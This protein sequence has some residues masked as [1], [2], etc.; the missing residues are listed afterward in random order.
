MH[1][2]FDAL[3]SDFQR[4]QDTLKVIIEGGGSRTGLMAIKE[5]TADIGLSSFKFD[6]NKTL[7]DDHQVNQRVVAYDGIV[8]I[9]NTNNPLKQLTN[10]QISQIYSG[11]VKD[12]SEIGGSQG[13]IKPIVR[14]SNS[15]TQRFFTNYF[16]VNEV[17]SSAI[18]AKENHEIVDEVISSENGIGFIGYAYYTEMVNTVELPHADDADS[19][20]V[21]YIPPTPTHLSNGKYPLK[22]SLQIYYHREQDPRVGAFLAYLNTDRAKHIIESFG[23]IAM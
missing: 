4:M 18:V 1:E 7:G 2:T 22:R 11:E 9:N 15:G 5:S 13:L 21:E 20:L 12:W 16:R 10:S 8:V 6:L 14:D 19:N 17:A 3:A 23:L